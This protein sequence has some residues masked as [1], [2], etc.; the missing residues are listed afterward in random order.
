MDFDTVNDPQGS[1]SRQWRVA[2]APTFVPVKNGAAVHG[3]TGL[4]SYW[5]LPARVRLADVFY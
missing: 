1:I 4:G 2:V 3:T 5:G